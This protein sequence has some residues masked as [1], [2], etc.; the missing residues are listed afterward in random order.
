MT[1][2]QLETL[3]G[4][5]Y[6]EE[7]AT[8]LIAEIAANYVPKAESENT[9]AR[10]TDLEVQLEDAERNASEKIAELQFTSALTAAIGTAKGKNEKA[11]TALLDTET[12]KT[13]K[14]Q[15]EDIKTAL[16]AIQKDAGYLFDT[17]PAAPPYS[18]GTGNMNLYTGKK[19]LES[20]IASKI[21]E[22]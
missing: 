21:F 10:I 5:A 18:A 22:K 7:L 17:I 8:K 15:V 16:A 11:I 13:S 6:S 2:E 3:L 9:A 4:D 20:E 1:K 14:N 12:L 19:D